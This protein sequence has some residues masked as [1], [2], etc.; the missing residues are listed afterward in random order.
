[1]AEAPNPKYDT[2]SQYNKHQ[3][4]CEDGDCNKNDECGCCPPGL[5]AV[6]DPCGKHLGCL[7]PNDA[8]HYSTSLTKCPEGYVK[9][10]HPTTGEFIGCLSAEDFVTVINTLNQ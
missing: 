7:T 6:V 2:Q 1:M 9:A 4:G 3:A 5:V 10:L 8:E